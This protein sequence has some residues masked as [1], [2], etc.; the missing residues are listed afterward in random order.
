MGGYRRFSM[1]VRRFGATD[2]ILGVGSLGGTVVWDLPFGLPSHRLYVILLP[3]FLV[4]IVGTNSCAVH[5][6]D[7]WNREDEQLRCSSPDS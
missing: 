2:A 5:F 1:C 6:P 7:S 3:R 4:G